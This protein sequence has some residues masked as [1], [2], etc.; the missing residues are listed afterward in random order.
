MIS[1]LLA[2]G[3]GAGGVQES[4]KLSL[5][6]IDPRS[7]IDMEEFVDYNRGEKQNPRPSSPPPSPPSNPPPL[8]ELVV[9]DATLGNSYALYG[10]RIEARLNP[11]HKTMAKNCFSGLGLR[12]C[13]IRESFKEQAGHGWLMDESAGLQF[14]GNEGEEAGVEEYCLSCCSMTR[15]TAKIDEVWDLTCDAG[16]THQVQSAP[17]TFLPPVLTRSLALVVHKDFGTVLLHGVQIFEER[18]PGR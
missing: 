13:K 7:P 16:T 11:D 14:L 5:S 2:V 12:G 8:A 1:V 4:K 17:L 6:S 18:V 15:S 3:G 9:V 10:N